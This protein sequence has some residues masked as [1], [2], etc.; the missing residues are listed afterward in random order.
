MIKPKHCLV[1]GGAGFIGAHLTRRLL[2]DGWKVT[3]ID[4]LSAG[5]WENLPTHPNLIKHRVSILENMSPFVTGQEVI[6]HLAALPRVQ[7]SLAQPRETHA[8]NVTGTLNLLAAVKDAQIEKFILASSSSVYGQQIKLPLTENMP[9]HPMSPYGLQKKMAEDYCLLFN[10]LWGVPTICLR[11]FNVYGPGMNPDDAYAN[12]IP[13]FISL[14]TQNKIPVI[15][16]NGRQARDFTFIDDVVEANIL[17]ARSGISGEI[18][19]I[20]A[21]NMISVN[22][23]MQLLNRFMGKNIQPVHGPA[24][25][26]PKVTLSSCAKAKKLLGWKPKVK[27]ADG[28][29]TVIKDVI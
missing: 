1:T 15:N 3:V 4:D 28:L 8:I 9:P 2:K 11:Y 16:G 7:R 14:M 26:E 18:I 20:G 10:K 5:K 6:F 13:K 22:E 17:A 19:N 12:L 29:K 21:G 25:V 24:L 27:F 23:V